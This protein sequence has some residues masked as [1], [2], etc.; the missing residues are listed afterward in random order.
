MFDFSVNKKDGWVWT[1]NGNSNNYFTIIKLLTYSKAFFEYTYIHHNPHM[2][3]WIRLSPITSPKIQDPFH[4]WV[5]LQ[6]IFLVFFN[7]RTQKR[8][9]SINESPEEMILIFSLCL[10]YNLKW[11]S[12]IGIMLEADILP[13]TTYFGFGSLYRLS[14]E[15]NLRM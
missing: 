6:V 2:L 12:Y 15:N 8:T 4:V 11:D 5:A 13:S 9:L 1:K 14:I 7:N 3:K 10:C